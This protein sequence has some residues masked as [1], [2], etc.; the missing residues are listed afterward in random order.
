MKIFDTGHPKPSRVYKILLPQE[1]K[2]VQ[3]LKQFA[4]NTRD[5]NDGYIHLS[6]S[7]QVE[8]IVEKYYS[9]APQIILLEMSYDELKHAIQWDQKPDGAVFP[10]LYHEIDLNLVIKTYAIKKSEFEWGQLRF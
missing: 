7:H 9:D 1:W 6:M 3:R 8:Q 4:G 5:Q 10:H 2:D